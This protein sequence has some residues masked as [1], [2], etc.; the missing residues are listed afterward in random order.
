M[1]SINLEAQSL[2]DTLVKFNRVHFDLLSE[3]GRAIFFPNLGI[4]KQAAEASNTAINA[5]VGIALED[6][7]SPVFLTDIGAR[8]NLPSQEVFT[9]TGSYG[10]PALRDY[11]EKM[12]KKKN[13][14]LS[15][16]V[17]NPVVTSGITHGISVCGYLF[18]NPD[19]EVITP[20]LFW[21]NYRLIIENA[22]QGK[23]TT[24]PTFDNNR[25][26]VAGLKEMLN[27]RTGKT[28]VILNFPNNPT[29][30]SPTVLEAEEIVA[31]LTE[32][33][34]KGNETLVIC[35]DA[36]FG[37]VFE[38]GVYQE[39]LFAKLAQAHENLLVVKADGATKE[40]YVWGFRVG[41]LTFSGKNISAESC[42]AFEE[43]TAGVVR[44][45]ISNVSHLSQSLL[46]AAFKSDT[47]WQE[48]DQKYVLL[49]E[50]FLA[51]K[52]ALDDPKYAE[53]FTPLPFNSG[54]FMC[55]KLKEGLD[56]NEIRLKLIKEFNTGTIAVGKHIRVAF[57]SVKKD[58][59]KTVFEHIYNACINQNHG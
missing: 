20:D 32:H 43:K 40:E 57:S 3:K 49:K 37:L 59:I 23:L 5:T 33:A 19:D 48:K 6:D 24:F 55:V 41:F 10:K 36:Y 7:G 26:N 34:S 58:A 38:D 22:Y 44:G 56:A 27:N 25:F 52:E 2:N 13:P 8:V 21:G 46:L 9:Y 54:Y 29:G 47:Y 53:V 12:I 17:S 31:C 14:E 4:V 1:S 16:L 15:T 50:R 30:Y 42:A 28:I 45:S 11:W 51:V 18:I 39:S 35:D